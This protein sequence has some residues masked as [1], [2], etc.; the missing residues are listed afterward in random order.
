MSRS[1]GTKKIRII[2]VINLALALARGAWEIRTVIRLLPSRGGGRAHAQE[3]HAVLALRVVRVLR[4][5]T[6]VH[7]HELR[8]IHLLLVDLLLVSL[9]LVDLRLVTRAGRGIRGSTITVVI[10]R[11]VSV[12]KKRRVASRAVGTRGAQGMKSIS[13]STA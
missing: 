4:V 1:H 8:V 3:I 10:L 12:V 11:V 9:G 13:K 7:R 5:N 6:G 2:T